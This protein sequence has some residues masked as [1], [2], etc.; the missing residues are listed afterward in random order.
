MIWPSPNCQCKT[1]IA[2]WPSFTIVILE[3]FDTQ[4]NERTVNVQLYVLD[5][6]MDEEVEVKQHG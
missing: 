6:N 5:L 3:V 4:D 2:I 1:F